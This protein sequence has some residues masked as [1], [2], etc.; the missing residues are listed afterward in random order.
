M[1]RNVPSLYFTRC[2]SHV[3]IVY[4]R[5]LFPIYLDLIPV[6]DRVSFGPDLVNNNNMKHTCNVSKLQKYIYGHLVKCWVSHILSKL[7][8]KKL[9]FSWSDWSM[10]EHSEKQ[11]N[12]LRSRRWAF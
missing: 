3:Q 9:K 8:H 12:D 5:A 11:V 4:K 10:D 1:L 6:Y 2:W 7:D